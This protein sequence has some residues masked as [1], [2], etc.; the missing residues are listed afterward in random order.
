MTITYQPVPENKVETSIE[1]NIPFDLIENLDRCFNEESLSP[2]KIKKTPKPKVAKKDKK[3]SFFDVDGRV[4]HDKNRW[5]DFIGFSRQLQKDTKDQ[6]EDGI[7]GYWDDYK[8]AHSK[9][10]IPWIDSKAL[11]ECQ[12]K[13]SEDK[14]RSHTSCFRQLKLNKSPLHIE[15]FSGFTQLEKEFPNFIEVIQ[16]YKGFF[17]L[18]A[19][20]KATSYQAP[21]PLLL[22]GNP[23]IGK[24]RFAKRLAQVLGT[25][26]KFLDSNSITSGSILTGHNA[27]WRGADAGFIFKTLAPCPNLSPVILL[28]EVDKLSSN[29]DYSPFSTF[30]QLL[31]PEN[32]VNIYDEFLE[33]EFNGS[34]IIYILTANDI[35]DIPESLLSRMNVIDIK[36]PD[37][38]QMK[39]ISQNIFTEL[40]AGSRLFKNDLSKEV[41]DSLKKS[42][43]REVYQLLSKNL[44]A[45][46]ANQAKKQ[47]NEFFIVPEK[48]RDYKIGF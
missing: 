15:D 20:R 3:V 1:K 41:L 16:L 6:Y 17:I 21:R 33:L 19:S 10:L 27:S 34:F 40:L 35:K 46:S 31:E 29:R 23:G 14:D 4:F 18:N 2:P 44:F 45:L 12:E 30:H 48:K 36:N 47:H 38:E 7:R 28:D 42:S 22:L 9:P 25:D 37:E 13:I 5:I 11:S 8:N 43:P 24:T 26:Y 32:S 39:I